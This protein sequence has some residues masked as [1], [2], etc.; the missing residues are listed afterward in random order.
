MTSK[1]QQPK[2]KR[3]RNNSLVESLR[4]L[5]GGVVK[6]FAEEFIGEMPKDI[7]TQ[8]GLRPQKPSEKFNPYESFEEVKTLQQ[9]LRQTEIVRREEQVVFSVEEQTTKN[10][11]TALLQEAQKL[12]KA[13]QSLSSEVQ[14]AALQTPVEVGTYHVSFFEKLISFLQSLTQKIENASVWMAAWSTK[15]K[16]QPSYWSQVKQSGSKFMLSQER[17]MST[18]AG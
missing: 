17:Y 7:F 12:S 18:Q 2:Q 11:V 1:G 16:K 5:G 4:D 3:L 6:G 8:T 14:V 9:K 10:Q 13:V 15:T